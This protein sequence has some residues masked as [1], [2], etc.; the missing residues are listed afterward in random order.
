MDTFTPGQPAWIIESAFRVREVI[1]IR[2]SGNLATVRFAD[3]PSGGIRIPVS[4]LYAYR[5]DAEQDL[6]KKPKL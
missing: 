3:N 1:V 2:I 5:K 4:R 6:K